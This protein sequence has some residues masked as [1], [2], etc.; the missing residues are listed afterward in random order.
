[1]LVHFADNCKKN[2][3]LFFVALSFLSIGI[4]NAQAPANDNCAGAINIP[5]PNGNFGLGNFTS[6]QT[7]LTNATVQSGETFAPA[8]F[9]AALDKKSVWYK[10]SIPTIRAVRVTLTQPGTTITAG[11]AG[12]AVYQTNSCLPANADIS[13]KLTP[14][15]T[16]GNTYHPCVPSGDY[17]IQVSANLN[18]NGPITIQLEISDQTGAAYDH[19]NQAYAFGTVGYYAH[20]I[21][22]NTECQSI[23]D[24]S[25]I[26]SA[27]SNPLDYNKTAWLTFKTPSY[28]DYIV[29]Q[30]SGTG[31]V[32]SYFPSNNNLA[33]LR[34]FAYTLY[35]GNAVTTPISSLVTIK[36]CDSLQTNGYYSDYRVFKCS[37]LDTGTTYSIQFFIK[38][39]FSDD[40]RWSILVGGQGPTKAPKPILSGVPAPNA[41]GI[42]P[43]SPAGTLTIVDD[44]WGC[45]SRHNNSVCNPSLPDTGIMYNGGKYNLSSF[46]TF[47]L[48]STCGIYF[49]AYVTQCGPQPLVRVFKQGLTNSCSGLDT[50]NIIGT[51]SRI[52]FIDCLEPGNYTVQVSGQDPTVYYGQ[53]NYSSAAYNYEQCLSNNLGTSFRLNMTAYYRTASNKYSLSNTGKFDSINRVGSVMQPLADRVAYSSISDTIGCKPTVQPIDTTCSP[54]ND[55]VIYRQFVLNDSGIV[56]FSNL[57][58]SAYSPMRYRLY[59]GDANAL[60]TAQNVFAFPNKI[61]GLKPITECFDFNTNCTNRTACVVP[62]TYTFTTMAGN[63]DVGRADKPVFTFVRTRTKHATP[64]AAQNLGSLWDTLGVGGGSITTDVDEWGCDDNAVAINGTQ[65]CIVGGNPATKAIY[66]QFYLNKTS[67]VRIE[68]I[69]YY[70]C[71]ARA[72]GR[73]KLFYGKA[74]DGFTGLSAVGGQWTDFDNAGATAGCDLLPPGWYTVVSYNQ[75]P[76]YDSTFRSLNLEGRYNSAVGYNDEFKI[77]VTPSCPEPVY[78]RPYKASVAAGNTPHSILLVNRVNSTPAYPRTDTTYI[79]PKEN[80][81]CTLDTPFAN[82]PIKTCEP[83]ANRVA[84]YVF[85]TTQECFLQINTAGYFATV[86][87]KDVRVDSLQFATLNPIQTCNNTAG[88]IQFCYFQ[89]GTYTLVIFA[90]D[91]NVCQSVTPSI[92]IDVTNKFSR[93]DYA[94][95]AY[96]FGIVPPDSV[97]HYGKVGDINPLNSGRAPSNDIFYCTTGA[98]STDPTEPVCYTSINPN[99]YN[100]GPNKPLYDSAFNANIYGSTRRNIWYT[101]VIDKPG[102]ISVKVESKTPAREYQQ[103]FT[104]YQSNVD[105]TLPFSTVASSGEI[106][107]TIAQ[108]LRPIVTNLQNYYYCANLYNSV[109]FYRDPCTSIPTRYYILVENVNAEPYEP[110][111][112]LPNTLTEVSILIDSINLIAPKHDHYSLAGDIGTVGVGTFTGDVDNFSCATKDPTDPIYYYG[113]SGQCQKT[114]WYKFTSTI[115]GNVRYRAK[116]DGAYK[117][118]YYNIQL[119]KPIIP[120][121]SSSN[122][123]QIQ[124]YAGYYDNNTGATWA[125]C[126]VAPGTYYLLLTGCAQVNEYE[127]PEIQLVEAVGDFCSRAIP[128]VLNGTGAV[129]ASVLVNCHTIGTDYGE[130]GPELTCPQ[131]AKT[132]D[133]KSSWFR[134]DIGGTDTLDVTT[135]L[136][137]NTNAASSDIKYRLMTGNCGAMQEQ[138]C[139]QDALTQNTYQ[140]LAPGQSYFV[141][142]FTPITKFNQAVTGTIDLKLSAI[143][144]ADTCAPLAN[145]LANANFTSLFN[146]TTDDSVKFVNFS[147]YGTSISYKWNFGY[148][149]QTSNAVSPSFFYPALPNDVTYTVK[150]VVENTSCNKKD[151]S[152]KTV[153]VPGRP[154]INFG[155]DIDRCDGS[156]ITL[157]ATSHTGATYLWQDG[158]SADTLNITTPG[159]NDYWVKI[160][161]NNCSSIDTV[162]VVI[163][164]IAAKP[165]QQIILCTDSVS[166]NASRGQGESYNWNTGAVIAAIFASKPGVYWVDIKYFTC[167]YRDSFVVNNVATARPLGNDTNACLSNDGYVLNARTAGAVSYTWQDGSTADTFKVANPGQYTVSINFGNCLVKD[168]VNVTGFPAPINSSIDT[169]ICFGSSFTLPWGRVVNTAGVYRDTVHFAAGCDS[170]VTK[171]TLTTFAKPNIGSDTTVCLVTAYP[172]NAT[173]TGAVS[174]TWQDGSTAATFNALSPGLYWVSVNFGTCSSRDSINIIGSPAPVLNN[175]DT[176]ICLGNTLTLPW[177]KLVNSSGIYTDTIRT[178][179][180]CDSIIKKVTLTVQPK[181]ALGMDTTVSICGSNNFNL[182]TAYF[183]TGLT[184]SW[185]LATITVANPVAISAPGIYQLIAANSNGCTD[186]TLLTLSISPKPNIGNDTAVSI[187]QGNTYNLT[188][189]YSTTGLT[190]NWTKN[191]IAVTTPSTVNIAGTYQ[192]IAAN[193]FGCADTALVDLSSSAKPNLGNDSSINICSGT[194]VNLTTIYSTTSLTPV[195]KYNNTIVANPSSVTAN[196][197]YQLIATAATSCADTAL[198]TIAYNAKPILGNDT[199]INICSGT[200]FNLTTVYNTASLSSN[201]TLNSVAVANP[202]AIS[203]IG[204]YQIITTNSFTCADTAIVI[205]AFNTNPNLGND[206]ALSICQGNVYNLSTLY[207]TTGLVS[208]WTKAGIAVTTPSA[209]NIA[210]VYQLIASNAV[211]C[212]D[213]AL[214]TLSI[215]TKPFIGNDTSLTICEGETANLTPL[216]NTAGLTSGWTKN[217]MAIPN[218]ASESIAGQY[219]LIAASAQGCSDTAIA[220]LIVNPKPALGNDKDATICEGNTY[221]LTTAFATGSNAN[222]WTKN[223]VIVSSPAV[224]NVPGVYQLFSTNSFGCADTALVTLA[225]VSNPVL[226]TNNPPTVCSPQTVDLT[227]P[228]ITAGSTS[229][230]AFSYWKDTAA[231]TLYA[232]ATAAIGGQYFI[233][234]TNTTGCFAIK[235]VSVLYYPLPLVNAGAD[236]AI[237]DKDSTSLSAT[238]TNSTAPVT[239]QWEPVSTGGINTPTASTTIVK[240]AATLQYIVTVK[241]GYG[242]NY[243]VS[244]SV[245]VTVQPPVVAFAGNDTNAVRGLPHQLMATGGVN[246]TWTPGS[247]LDNRYSQNP[248]ATLFTESMKYAVAVKDAAGCIGYDTVLISV[249]DDIRYYVPNAFSP[250]GDGINDL[251]RPIP[252]G[253]VSTEFFRIFNR[254]GELVFETN[255]WMKGWDGKY[256]AVPQ[257][258]GNYIWV[259]KGIGRNGKVIEMKGNVLLVK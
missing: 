139:V 131:G 174:Y 40:V 207:N 14:I 257:A 103:K 53:F 24:A 119:F 124:G 238:V 157:K 50:A 164:P 111:G 25:E 235:P 202:S 86:Y 230:L 57:T 73:K 11:D 199:A 173:T 15:V 98:A 200:S 244:D 189:L 166:I 138:S 249:Y 251:F 42:L 108:G 152:I 34:T 144:H 104:V 151:S 242:C 204:N 5:I 201:W 35:K 215:N 94:K 187:C 248:L 27:F 145:C 79:L 74:T 210:G 105:G 149:G 123:L 236:I 95:N 156:P 190:T 58:Y 41:I 6:S 23:E 220:T 224:V 52:G 49:D 48:N 78:N 101:F 91:A 3:R 121:D 13:T 117:Y 247:F 114:L 125:E 107:S 191:G 90:K 193:N 184:T 135:Y 211:G 22:F 55:K 216:Y 227:A 217:N 54:V 134:M 32:T 141:Q 192:L 1:M 75:G 218:P 245:L 155:N 83:T 60:A 148:N 62:G 87:N 147:T 36:A 153:T 47:T 10:F 56:D 181:P 7:V 162:K 113:N 250:N 85:K 115:T 4:C 30:L 89:P 203:A 241:D 77:S 26:C 229:G 63:A 31:A 44:V 167:T 71:Y 28:F 240:P 197:I 169:S 81:N 237:C 93:F 214:V 194:T 253:V 133:Y 136:V 64:F 209:V 110:G 70:Y 102:Y 195:W 256:K 126:C 212:K 122:G 116:I 20:K 21:D 132:T 96:D 175:I 186:T 92:Y 143:K 46:S 226:I 233:K 180:G 219:V 165:L 223:A 179:S 183:T 17:L 8:V 163:S 76:S 168:T 232:N 178:Y 172:L 68:N 176:S 206:T 66:R 243:L 112:T 213:T 65:P 222:Q 188:S 118:D 127:F 45:N 51:F 150:L 18:A 142:V 128:A 171:V 185:T 140:C 225:I 234:A 170:L 120:G 130:F 9:V 69:Y 258:I 161:Y 196:G 246:Y 159:N 12:F 221:N 109:Q 137:E 99:V 29:L 97:W 129:T 228:A 254:Y 2:K 39:D 160:N 37:D 208:N 84:Y 158:S 252:V 106:D 16:F 72:Y 67:L 19:P 61:T 231:T 259:I 154:Y 33:T 239:Y 59:Q 88:Y 198:V 100:S 255:Q 182:T 80:F 146:C 38:K 43:V 82:H 177:G 205:I